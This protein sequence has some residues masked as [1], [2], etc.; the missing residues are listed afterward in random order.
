MAEGTQRQGSIIGL[1][2][3]EANLGDYTLPNFIFCFCFNT[4][5]WGEKQKRLC[6]SIGRNFLPVLFVGPEPTRPMLLD[7]NPFL[8]SRNIRKRRETNQDAVYT[9]PGA[10]QF[11]NNYEIGLVQIIAEKLMFSKLSSSSPQSNL[12][13]SWQL[14]NDYRTQL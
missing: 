3:M 14:Q 8:P 2:G 1:Q 7:Q 9:M 5:G 13:G 4:E 10:I 12:D 6:L 11:H